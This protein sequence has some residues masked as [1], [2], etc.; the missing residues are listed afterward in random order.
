MDTLI[1]SDLK[2]NAFSFFHLAHGRSVFII[3]GTF[4]VRYVR[5]VFIK[6]CFT[7]MNVF[8]GPTNET[9]LILSVNVVI[10]YGFQFLFI[11]S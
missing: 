1:F 2:G 9:V 6:R 11:N 10:H 8:S 4:W 5:F 3:S 7:L